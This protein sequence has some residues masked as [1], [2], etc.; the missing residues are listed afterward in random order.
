MARPRSHGEEAATF[1]ALVSRIGHRVPSEGKKT[2]PID[3]KEA[4]QHVRAIG[5][6]VI[7][8]PLLDYTSRRLVLEL[9][10]AAIPKDIIVYKRT[11]CL[12][13]HQRREILHHDLLLFSGWLLATEDPVVEWTPK[14]QKN[15]RE[16]LT[17]KF[18]SAIGTAHGEQAATTT[19]TRGRYIGVRGDRPYANWLQP[20]PATEGAHRVFWLDAPD[21][22]NLSS[23]FSMQQSPV[24]LPELG[25]PRSGFLE[26]EF[27]FL[28]FARMAQISH[29][30]GSQIPKGGG[31]TTH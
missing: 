20:I 8:N 3:Q 27:R 13:G 19:L 4:Q 14:G 23:A 25:K 11:L 17:S 12:G 18:Y 26:P 29:E 22:I 15:I 5:K 28:L 10:A 6:K 7:D 31:D 1:D 21:S 2:P 30:I 24:A 9:S 16:Y